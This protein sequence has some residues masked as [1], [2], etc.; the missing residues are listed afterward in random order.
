MSDLSREHIAALRGAIVD[1]P[2]FC[3]GVCPVARDNFQI[4]YKADKE[5]RC[6]DLSSAA[7]DEL[8]K[9]AEACTPATFGRNNEDVLDESYRKAGKLDRDNFATT[10]HPLDYETIVDIRSE[11]LQGYDERKP[12]RAQLYKLNV[13]GPGAFFKAHKDTARAE[14]MFGSLVVVYPTPHR[15]GALILHHGG[16][17]WR[18]DSGELL[19]AEGAPR[20]AYAAFYGDVE[21]EVAPVESGFRVTLTYNLYFAGSNTEA[22]GNK[23][24]PSGGPL[25][26]S[27]RTYEDKFKEILQRLLDDPT[28]LPQGGTL[29]FGL[30]YQYPV[31][32]GRDRWYDIPIKSVSVA[33]HCL[34]GS[35]AIIWKVE[36]ELSLDARLQVL[37]SDH[38]SPLVMTDEFEEISDSCSVNPF[39]WYLLQYGGAKIVQSRSTEVDDDPDDLRGSDEEDDYSKFPKEKVYWVTARS[40]FN[41]FSDPYAAYG[42]DAQ[43]AFAHGNLCLIVRIGPPGARSRTESVGVR[44][45]ETVDDKRVTPV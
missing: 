19:S 10:Y 13:Y 29:G 31:E 34:K 18:F 3:S 1:K 38:Q 45:T 2:P 16:Q 21:H 9:L 32:K 35:D 23:P 17:E 6:I 43:L 7:D 5:V 22:T 26:T 11:L 33:Q 41:K 12:I 36:Q 8:R 4:Y 28:F 24:Q 14:N 20:L 39:N 40:P 27:G 25:L 30:R 42:N 44:S 37:Y 15:G